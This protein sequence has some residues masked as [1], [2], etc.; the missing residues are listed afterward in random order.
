MFDF[1]PDNNRATAPVRTAL[2]GEKTCSLLSLTV[3]RRRGVTSCPILI[4][5]SAAIDGGG[6]GRTLFGRSECTLIDPRRSK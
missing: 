6:G 5:S 1:E 3:N 2:N 4:Q